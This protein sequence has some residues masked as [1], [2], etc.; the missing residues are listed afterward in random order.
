MTGAGRDADA[1]EFLILAK[2][3]PECIR[4]RV[5]ERPE[6]FPGIAPG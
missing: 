2:K 1:D 5:P 4:R 6:A 3:I